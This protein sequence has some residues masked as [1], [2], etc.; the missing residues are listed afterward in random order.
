MKLIRP[1]TIR[2]ILGLKNE[3]APKKAIK[4][5][6]VAQA[7]DLSKYRKKAQNPPSTSGA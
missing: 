3:Y 6:T 1:I 7:E 2:N 5:K 4:A